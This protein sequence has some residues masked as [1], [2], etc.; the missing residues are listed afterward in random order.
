MVLVRLE[1]VCVYVRACVYVCEPISYLVYSSTL[2]S[3]CVHVCVHVCV[4]AG[5]YPVG[6]NLHRLRWQPPPIEVVR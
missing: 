3:V 2:P 6:G 1:S 5:G 4:R